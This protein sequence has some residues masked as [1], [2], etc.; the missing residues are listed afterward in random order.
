MK[1]VVAQKCGFCLGVKNAIRVAHE[2][3]TDRKEVYSLGPVIHNADVVDQLARDGL[4]TIGKVEQIPAGTVLIRS[5]GATTEEIEK[6]KQKGLE[7]VDA[8]CVLVKRVQKIARQLYDD[9]YQVVIIGDENHPEVQAVV[10]HAPNIVVVADES[11]LD[12]LPKDKR[13][14][15]ICQ[16]TQS[17]D[18]FGEMV[19]RIAKRGFFELKVV[20]TLC[21]EAI[22]RQESAVELCKQVDVMFVLGGL[23]SANT[24]KL[25]ELCKKYNSQ[26][27]H[28]Q[29]W[30]ELDKT[31]L[32][33]KTIAGVTAGASTPD[34]IIE[35]FVEKLRAFDPS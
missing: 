30:N 21:K 17:P 31:I 4:R 35:E 11:D 26:T 13:L 1:V 33:G 27:F 16:T 34:Q 28:L 6:I 25:A 24:R 29:N 3:L 15:I 19:G 12:K 7:I 18:H 23:N 2:T 32:S 9:G 10:G 5:H 8:T 20:N 14:G 22:S